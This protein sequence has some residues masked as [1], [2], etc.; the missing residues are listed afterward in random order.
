VDTPPPPP[1]PNSIGRFF[2]GAF[3]LF[4]G[5]GTLIT[6]SGLRRWAVLPILVNLF[7]FCLV[8]VVSVW[9][10][11]HYA[12]QLSETNWGL[13]WGSLA[14]LVA[15]ALILILGFFTFGLVAPVF[16]APF[17]ELLSQ[18]TETRFTGSTGELK[19]RPFVAEMLRALVSA[20]TIFLLEM[21][22]VIPALLLLFIPFAGVF[23]FAIPAGFFLALAYMDYS[24]DRRKL[25][26]RHKLAFCW[27]HSPEVM[28]FGLM[29]Y[30]CMLVP[31][32]NVLLIP[33]AA[34]AGTRLF[35]DLARTEPD[36]GYL[37][38]SSPPDEA[39][40]PEPSSASA[41]DASA[42]GDEGR[43]TSDASVS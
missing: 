40:A 11:A 27:R 9:A 24:L 41:S 17:N 19:D 36:K 38:A 12:R 4:R 14:G 39:A 13:V 5:M 43:G 7:V 2:I 30:A 8:A 10:A 25:R 6:G 15:F 20:I 21:L 16:A 32:V 22:V 31:F 18:R 23:L 26:L 37:P 34:V 42:V 1:R 29:T 28:G 3:Y 35:V 33:V